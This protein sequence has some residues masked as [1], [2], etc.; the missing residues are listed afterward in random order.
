MLM[1]NFQCIFFCHHSSPHYK[2]TPP[3]NDPDPQKDDPSSTEA[4]SSS[5]FSSTSCATA[6]ATDCST[7]L[8]I[9]VSGTVSTTVTSISCLTFSQCSATGKNILVIS[10]FVNSSRI[11]NYY[12]NDD[13][14]LLDSNKVYDY[15]GS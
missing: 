9:S 3:V 13:I 6:T 14:S 2:P 1:I 12:V 8:A 11:V 4:S 5:T 15:T 10:P 7:I